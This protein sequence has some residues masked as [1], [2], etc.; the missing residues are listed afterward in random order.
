[1]EM[2]WLLFAQ[3][4]VLSIS[5]H[6]D[7]VVTAILYFTTDSRNCSRWLGESTTYLHEPHKLHLQHVLTIQE[8]ESIVW[9][10]IS[11]DVTFFHCAQLLL[12]KARIHFFQR[13]VLLSD[14]FTEK[15]RMPRREMSLTRHLVN[16]FSD[17]ARKIELMLY[18][19]CYVCIESILNS[20]V[21]MVLSVWSL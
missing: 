6:L 13:W 21:K 12:G 11:T 20:I 10:L 4:P 15:K 3:N 8:T 9:V 18:L 16:I 1:M 19:N 2:I 14:R 17:K 7:W 5:I